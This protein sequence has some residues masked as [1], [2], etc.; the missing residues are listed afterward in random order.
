M[1]LQGN[2]TYIDV[3]SLQAAFI[4]NDEK[5]IHVFLI[6]QETPIV[7]CYDSKQECHDDFMKLCMAKT[8]LL[9][10]Y[11]T[12]TKINKL[13]EGVL[14]FGID[15]FGY[16]AESEELSVRGLVRLFLSK[17]STC[18]FESFD[19]ISGGFSIIFYHE[20]QSS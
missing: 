3:A 11:G 15:T 9:V 16:T 6:P 2:R 14:K 19:I 8:K 4:Q 17:N 18:K 7:L 1:F 12:I 5:T 13:Y 10:L 20:T